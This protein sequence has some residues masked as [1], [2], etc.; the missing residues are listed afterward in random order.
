MAKKYIRVSKEQ[1]E[2]KLGWYLFQDDYDAYLALK[3]F[4]DGKFDGLRTGAEIVL[5]QYEE[6]QRKLK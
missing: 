1:V 4:F 6:A 5:F 2:Q 3:E